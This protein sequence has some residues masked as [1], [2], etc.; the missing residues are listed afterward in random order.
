[1]KKITNLIL[2]LCIALG[3]FAIL[4]GKASAATYSGSCGTK[5]NWSL[6]TATGV[7]TITGSGKMAD[8]S[9]KAP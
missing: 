6:D 5:L 8:Y 3:L 9:D 7:L 4:S 1:M 2:T